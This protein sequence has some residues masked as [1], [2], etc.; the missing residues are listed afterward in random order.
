MNAMN[1]PLFTEAIPGSTRPVNYF[2]APTMDGLYT[3]YAL[4][5][6][7]D[8]GVFPFIF[9]AYG[10]GGGGIDWLRGRIQ[11][12]AYIMERLLTA[13]YACAWGRYRSEVEL[14]FHHGGKLITD[15]RQGMDLLNR[16][17]LEFE[18]E[19]SIIEHV[20]NHP[21]VDGKRIGHIGVSHA[22]EMLFKIASHYPGVIQAGVACEPANHEFLDLTPD[23]TAFVNPETHLRNIEEMQMRAVD[24]VRARVNE[25]VAL[26]RISG[27]NIPI[28]VMGRDD[29]H[30]Q[31]IFRLSYDLLAESGK[32][33]EWISWDHPLHGYIFP[34]TDE[35]GVVLVDDVQESAID[36]LIAYLDRYLKP[37]AL[38]ATPNDGGMK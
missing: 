15:R 17:P 3:P 2:L 31:G 16:A 33:A 27:I 13:G 24:S 29:D 20:R 32:D 37:F 1:S 12:H 8:S 34:V 35:H 30:L 28:L 22:G 23:N 25:S 19:V 26:D 14:G 36:G 6:P 9:L 11:T 5:T 18:D 38:G 7:A 10:N 4:R 21:N